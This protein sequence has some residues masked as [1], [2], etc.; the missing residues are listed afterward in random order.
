MRALGLDDFRAIAGSSV[1]AMNAVLVGTG[2]LDAAETVWRNLRLRDVVGV[3]FRRL[4]RLPLWI[5][6]AIGSEF[7][8]FKTTRLSDRNDGQGR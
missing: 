6:A 7:S 8:P 5:I 2:R 3:S 4:P 1:G